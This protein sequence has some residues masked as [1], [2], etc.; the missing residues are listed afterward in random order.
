MLEIIDTKV[1]LSSDWNEIAAHV[2]QQLYLDA[3][4]DAATQHQSQWINF[5]RS[6]IR[7]VQSSELEW[8]V[9]SF[10]DRPS[11]TYGP[12]EFVNQTPAN[13]VARFKGRWSPLNANSFIV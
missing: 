7:N 13:N 1:V 8:T 2:S 11:V 6:E 9:A 4:Y 3:P 10:L 12:F 5:D